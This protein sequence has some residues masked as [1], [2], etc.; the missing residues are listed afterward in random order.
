MSGFQ[1]V[2]PSVDL[3]AACFFDSANAGANS[4]KRVVVHIRADGCWPPP[5][6]DHVTLWSRA[7][8]PAMLMSQPYGLRYE[9]LKAT[10]EYA[11]ENGLRVFIDAG[12]SW[13]YP[14]ATLAVILTRKGEYR[15]SKRGDEHARQ[16]VVNE[17]NEPLD[18]S[19]N[20]KFT[21]IFL[22]SGRGR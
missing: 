5:A 20:P 14:S 18:L 19:A 6:A 8:K 12:L 17:P 21:R 3:M 4:F 16:S 9:D 1:I 10:I 7:G 15:P 2:Q 11:E 13:H 22:G